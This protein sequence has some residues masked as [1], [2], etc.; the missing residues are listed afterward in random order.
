MNSTLDFTINKICFTRKTV[1][2]KKN[3]LEKNI[4]ILCKKN[5]KIRKLKEFFKLGS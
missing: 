2:V 5:Y 1:W 4:L 3:N